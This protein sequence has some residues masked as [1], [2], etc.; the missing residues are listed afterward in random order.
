M[1]AIWA[2]RKQEK[3]VVKFDLFASES[4]REENHVAFKIYVGKLYL[5]AY[6]LIKLQAALLTALSS[7]R[8]RRKLCCIRN[9]CCKILFGAT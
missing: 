7:V 2:E 3:Y 5:L 8:A 1:S 9:L 6:K 4:R